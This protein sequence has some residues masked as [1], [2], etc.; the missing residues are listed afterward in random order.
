MAYIKY[1]CKWG[2]NSINCHSD[3]SWNVCDCTVGTGYIGKYKSS[4]YMNRDT[5]SYDLLKNED[6]EMH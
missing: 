6:E 2:D 5:I 1:I 4:Y 3:S